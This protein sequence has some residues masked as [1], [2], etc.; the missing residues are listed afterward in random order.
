MGVRSATYEGL[1]GLGDMKFEL[2]DGGGA[3]TTGG[4]LDVAARR[5]KRLEI[6]R[7]WSYDWLVG[8]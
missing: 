6:S 3:F 8:W 2:N 7:G 5:V 1:R 4:G